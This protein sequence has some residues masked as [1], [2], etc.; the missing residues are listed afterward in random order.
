MGFIRRMLAIALGIWAV[1]Y[2]YGFLSS[3]IR[4]H[5][6]SYGTLLY[7]VVYGLLAFLAYKKSLAK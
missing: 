5:S 6:L 3:L 2:A 1:D 7:L 4:F